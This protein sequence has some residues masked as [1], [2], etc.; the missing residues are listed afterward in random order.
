[1]RGPNSTFV[2]FGR[3]P[4]VRVNVTVGHENTLNP[5]VAL[6]KLNV[7]TSCILW[8]H[9]CQ[10]LRTTLIYIPPFSYALLED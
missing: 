3:P 10:P 4:Y 2:R 1:M 8:L 5:K 9:S 6:N 7:R